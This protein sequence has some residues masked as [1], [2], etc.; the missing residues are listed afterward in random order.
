VVVADLASIAHA[1]ETAKL[2]APALV[3]VGDVVA[4]RVVPAER[5]RDA[6]PEPRVSGLR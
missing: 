6:A 2:E 4:R 3:V 1:V 5:R